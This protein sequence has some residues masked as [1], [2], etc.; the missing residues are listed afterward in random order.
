MWCMVHVVHGGWY[1]VHVVH[2]ARKNDKLMSLTIE[3]RGTDAF[4]V[5]LLTIATLP[6]VHS[7]V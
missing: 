2:G 4:D 3:A 7:C 6:F 5:P 1:M